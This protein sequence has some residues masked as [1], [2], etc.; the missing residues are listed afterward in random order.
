LDEEPR[1]WYEP[2]HLPSEVLS[3]F[4]AHA[5]TIYE[6]LYSGTCAGQKARGDK[7]VGVTMSKE[8]L[9]HEEKGSPDVSSSEEASG[10]ESEEQ[11]EEEEKVQDTGSVPEV[12][13]DQPAP[14]VNTN[15]SLEEAALFCWESLFGA[16]EPELS[17]EVTF[18]PLDRLERGLELHAK[19]LDQ[20]WEPFFEPSEVEG[21]LN[22]VP[23]LNATYNS[24]CQVK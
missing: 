18:W 6:D 4:K 19:I 14:D 23:D 7:P 11:D 24:F 13:T 1:R 2:N 16:T 20:E 3:I 12:R 21:N 17:P 22:D 15:P 5:P 10:T 8:P 9:V